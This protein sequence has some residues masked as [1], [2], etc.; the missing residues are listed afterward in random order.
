MTEDFGKLSRLERLAL[1]TA[2]VLVRAAIT[3]AIR[4]FQSASPGKQCVLTAGLAMLGLAA[5]ALGLLL[6]AGERLLH[7][8]SACKPQAGRLTHSMEE[9]PSFLQPD[10]SCI[11]IERWA[12]AGAPN[13]EAVQTPRE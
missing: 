4:K 11:G 8:V 9:S 12:N 13:I 7:V 10:Y 3:L 5:E 6:W 1:I 2:Q